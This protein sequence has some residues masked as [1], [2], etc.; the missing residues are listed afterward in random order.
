MAEAKA[1]YFVRETIEEINGILQGKVSHSQNQTLIL[2][3]L[4]N[5]Q[6][7]LTELYRDCVKNFRDATNVLTLQQVVTEFADS[8]AETQSN[9][10]QTEAELR[11]WGSL[12]QDTMQNLHHRRVLDIA[13]PDFAQFQ[14]KFPEL[15]AFSPDIIE[16][17]ASF[18]C[19]NDDVGYERIAKIKRRDKDGDTKE[20]IKFKITLKNV[21]VAI[22][23]IS[24]SGLGKIA[25][26]AWGEALT[27]KKLL[28]VVEKRYSDE[29]LFRVISNH[30]NDAWN[31]FSIPNKQIHSTYFKFW[32][33]LS[34]FRNYSLLFHSDNVCAL[35]GK[36]LR[37]GSLGFLPPAYLTFELP[38]EPLHGYCWDQRKGIS[39]KR[40]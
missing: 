35:C 40:K 1:F 28:R 24:E 12:L 3:H 25:C 6:D 27:E 14:T 16:N 22:L 37:F 34:W 4:S 31:S 2:V 29:I 26:F 39:R 23:S 21:V 15:H 17:I 32:S 38:P 33:F 18:F 20:E 9:G 7:A 11:K 8:F 36:L 10:D 19:S 30:C 13:Q 5:T